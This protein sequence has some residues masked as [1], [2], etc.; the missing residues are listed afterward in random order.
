M[1]SRLKLGLGVFAVVNCLWVTSA[2]ADVPPPDACQ[3]D[4]KACSNAGPEYNQAG[5]CKQA[6]CTRATPDGSMT[7]ECLRC[8]VSDTASA[9][10]DDEEEGCAFSPTK[11]ASPQWAP[12]LM[13]ALGAFAVTRRSARH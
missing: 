3:T 7:Y 12:L 6:M 11:T 9:S 10:N 2:R 13:L 5:E 8:E 4:G 1:T